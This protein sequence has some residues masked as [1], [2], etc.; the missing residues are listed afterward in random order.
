VRCAP[1]L[2]AAPG[3]VAAFDAAHL[4]CCGGVVLQRSFAAG[5][6]EECWCNRPTLD[7]AERFD[8]SSHGG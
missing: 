5:G 1:V 8:A 7:C 2:G 3:A 4:C 6:E